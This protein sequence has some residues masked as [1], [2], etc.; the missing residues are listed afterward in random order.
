MIAGLDG[1]R[2]QH[3]KLEQRDDGV[4]VLSFDRAGSSVNT[5]AQ[6]VLIELDTLLERLALDPPKGLVIRSAKTS[7]FIAGA[8]IKEFAEFDAKGKVNDAIRRG[9][10]V[11]QR[12]GRIA[13]P[14]GRRHPRLLHGRRHRDLAGLPLSRRQQ[15]RLHAH[16]P[17]GSEAG[18]LSRAGAAACACHDWS[19]RR[20]RST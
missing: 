10:Q 13:L 3:W 4:V 2:L 11:F 6:E 20:L 17:A 12:T 14:H 7:G 8:D 15:R 5:F 18:H 1:L 19:A 16:R 9:Q